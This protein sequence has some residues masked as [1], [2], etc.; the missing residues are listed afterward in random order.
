MHTAPNA[1]PKKVIISHVYSSDNKGDAALTSVLIKD[2]ERTFP[3]ADITILK[4]DEVQGSGTFEGV[5]EQQGFMSFAVNKFQHPL[6]KL[7]YAA[8]M[9]LATLTWAGLGGHGYLPRHL[10]RVAHIYREADLI[11]GVGGGYIRSRKG[12]RNR[13]NIPLLL[14][15]LLFAHLLGKPTVL[16][17]QSVGPFMNGYERSLVAFVLHRMN[18]ILIREDTS[19][20]VLADMGVTRNVARAIDSGFLLEANQNIDVR[21]NYAIPK[22]SFLIGVTVRAWLE[23][24]AQEKYERA[25]AAALDDAVQRTQGHV[26]LIPQV[27]ASKGD[28]DRMVSRRVHDLMQYGTQATVIEDEPDHTEIKAIYDKLDILLGTRFHSVIFSLTSYVPVVAI[29]YEYKTSGIMRD[30]GLGNWVVAIED[31]SKENLAE[32]LDKLVREKDQYTQRL[33]DVLPPYIEKARQTADLMA[34]AYAASLITD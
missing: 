10:R 1:S 13:M 22:K 15:P 23:G 7:L 24:E 16:Y 12:L 26:L 19:M 11:V 9:V 4:L 21:K 14:H 27:T 32:L 20:I 17:S 29:E 6:L 5:P 34:D 18:L 8:Y 2:I 25:V 30:L 31:V 3:S 33:H 28:D